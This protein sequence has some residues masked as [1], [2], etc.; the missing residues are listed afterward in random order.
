MTR[1][2]ILI[3]DGARARLF[4][5]GP[6]RGASTVK[7]DDCEDLL[8][9]ERSLPGREVFSDLKSG[10]NRPPRG[11]AYTYDDHRSNH[12]DE[13]E[14]RF[15]K[16]IAAAVARLI[17]REAPDW[18]VVVAEPRLLGMLRRP[19]DHELPA[20]LPRTELAADLSWH[21][22]PNIRAELERRGVLPESQP[23]SDTWRARAQ[24]P[25]KRLRRIEP[26]RVKNAKRETSRPRRG[27]TK[28]R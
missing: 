25:P 15:A 6:S 5:A 1:H 8:N 20:T 23:S 11:A 14:R 17:R 24:P 28:M 18:F 26:P 3:A 27:R 22:L 7:L 9:P 12:R 16:Q 10:R 19:L 13:N 2:C 4:M 21:A